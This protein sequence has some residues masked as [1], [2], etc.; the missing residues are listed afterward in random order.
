MVVYLYSAF[1]VD[2]QNLA[3]GANLYQ[4]LPSAILGGCKPTFLSHNGEIWHEGADLGPGLPLPSQNLKKILKG[5]NPLGK[6]HTKNYW[7]FQG[8]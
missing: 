1:S 8:L 6:I 4:K 2:P 5:Y 3:F 7:R